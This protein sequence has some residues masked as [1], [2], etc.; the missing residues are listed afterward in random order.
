MSYI[1]KLSEIVDK[2][3]CPECDYITRVYCKPRICSRYKKWINELL[4]LKEEET[5]NKK[6]RTRFLTMK[7]A[8]KD[9]YP[10]SD[11]AAR[12]DAMSVAQIQAIYFSLKER[13]ALD[14]RKNEKKRRDIFQLTIE[15]CFPEVGTIEVKCVPDNDK[16]EIDCIRKS[17]EGIIDDFEA[18]VHNYSIAPEKYAKPDWAYVE[19]LFKEAANEC[20]GR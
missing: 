14:K 17:L 12:V 7:N 1:L 20:A 11:W 3:P 10:T 15:D 13:G 16:K 5:M 4:S 8:V 2:T 18:Q 19:S 9:A 6:T